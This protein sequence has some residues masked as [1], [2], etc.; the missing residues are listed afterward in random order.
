MNTNFEAAMGAL[1]TRLQGVAAFET[2]GRRLIPWTQVSA[3]PAMFLRRVGTTDEQGS[4]EFMITTL[5]CEVWIYSKAGEDPRAIPD[6]ELSTLDQAVRAA[7]APDADYGVPRFTLG[8][9]VYWCRI[10][11]RSEY[12][13]GDLGGQGISLIPVRITLP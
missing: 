8:G 6:A 9:L 4:G 10:E 11:G 13:P 2:T 1:F 12:S 3:Q 7:F 5:E